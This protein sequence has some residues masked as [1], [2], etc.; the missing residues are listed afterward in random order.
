MTGAGVVH[1]GTAFQGRRLSRS[2]ISSRND[3]SSSCSSA[4]RVA[5]MIPA[6][7]RTA[8]YCASEERAVLLELRGVETALVTLWGRYVGLRC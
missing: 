6:P 4:A 1:R 8:S 2:S 3:G 5:P 7:T